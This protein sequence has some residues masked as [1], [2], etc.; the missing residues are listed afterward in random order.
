MLPILLSAFFYLDPQILLVPNA[1]GKTADLLS[2]PNVNAQIHKISRKNSQRWL[3]TN[4]HTELS[5]LFTLQVLMLKLRGLCGPHRVTAG[6][7]HRCS[8]Q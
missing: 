6:K 8:I 2:R 7:S 4:K 3:G 5:S 1:N